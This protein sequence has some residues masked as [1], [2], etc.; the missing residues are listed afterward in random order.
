VNKRALIVARLRELI[1]K[2]GDVFTE[3]TE[4]EGKSRRAIIAKRLHTLVGKF[5]TQFGK[6][7]PGSGNFGHEGRP[8]EVGGSGGGGLQWEA[9]DETT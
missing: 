8:G 4:A 6:G 5:Q 7:G 9:K 3:D 2:G 1:V